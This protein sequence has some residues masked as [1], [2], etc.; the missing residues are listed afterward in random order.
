VLRAALLV[1]AATL[2][3]LLD[4]VPAQLL[5]TEEVAAAGPAW[6]D[7]RSKRGRGQVSRRFPGKF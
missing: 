6:G 1:V 3:Q 4:L 7:R 2:E 5:D